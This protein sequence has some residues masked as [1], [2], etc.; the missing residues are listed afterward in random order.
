MDM[1]NIM[2]NEI[3]QAEKDKL[4]M[5]LSYVGSNEQT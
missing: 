2:V 3:S 5:I 4:H 1:E